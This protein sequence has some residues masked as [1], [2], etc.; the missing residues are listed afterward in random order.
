MRRAHRGHHFGLSAKLNLMLIVGIILISLGL[1]Q[2]TYTVYKQKVD[3]IYFQQA[4]T[5]VHQAEEGHFGY[6]LISY[7]RE[8]VD[9][10]EFREVHARAVEANDEKIIENWMRAQPPVPYMRG[11]DESDVRDME[12]LSLYGDYQ[13]LR[14]ELADIK[15][16]FD[17]DAAYLQYKADGITYSLL[18]PRK[19][20]LFIGTEKEPIAAFSQYA[21]GDTIPPTIYPYGDG[22]FCTACEPIVEDWNGADWIPA[23]VYVD[24][25]M[26]DVAAERRWF[27]VNTAVYIVLQTLVA[28]AVSMLLTRRLATKPL[29]QLAEATTGFSKSED[30]FSRADVIDLPIR[31]E[32]EI[33]ELYQE[34]QSME[35]RIVDSADRLIRITSERERVKT[36]LDMAARIQSS[37]L[38]RKFPAFPDRPEFDLFA[39]MDPAEEVGGD[40]YDFFMVDD[41]HLALV[42]A[43]VSDK[44]VPAALFMMSAK[45]IISYRARIGGTPGEILTSANAQLCEDNAMNMFVTVWLGILELSTGRLT[46]ASAGHESPMLMLPNEA[47]EIHKDKRGVAMGVMN[48]IAYR[49]YALDLKPGSKLFVYTD[50]LT[51]AG[52]Q[53]V[54]IFG[55]GRILQVLNAD[56][57]GSPK[58]LLANVHRAVDDFTDGSRQFDDMTMLC[59]EYRGMDGKR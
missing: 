4:K 40:F 39:S 45:N 9:T 6:Q 19:N 50:G 36:E 12:R 1:L 47:F 24:I 21:E 8:K 13:E 16:A 2:I 41:D 58:E 43:D 49:D 26:R 17:I 20:L 59:L 54:A 30:G 14:T 56:P 28:M 10:D 38:P 22:W 33:G 48:H 53:R 46:C 18:D 44:G 42:I 32:D 23:Q 34:I 29:K 57:D 25:D 7:L 52:N 11:Y 37:A 3:S 51:K 5:A 31:S 55:T 15:D 27:L 35:T